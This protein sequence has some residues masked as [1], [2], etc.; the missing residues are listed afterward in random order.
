[1]SER[2]NTGEYRQTVSIWMATATL[3]S[4][5]PLTEDLDVDV[6]VVGAGIVG[7]SVAYLLA[8][9]GK[10]VVVIDDGPIGGGNTARTTAHLACE[11]DDR[12]SEVI[13]VRGLE[14]AR[15]A[16]ES[17]AAAISQIEAIVAEEAIDCDFERLDGFLFLAPQSERKILDDELKAAHEVGFTDVEMLGGPP[18]RGL[19]SDPCLVFPRQAQFHPLKYLAGLCRAIERDGGRIYCGTHVESVVGG[20]RAT[21]T[22]REGRTVRAGAAVVATNSPIND[23]VTTH[24]KQGPYMTYVVGLRAEPGAIPRG[25]YWD[26]QDPYHYVRLQTVRP[27]MGEAYDVLIVGG[28]DHKTGQADDGARRL[29]ALAAWA[30]ERFPGLG[31]VMYRWSGMVFESIDGAAFIGKNPGED[32]VYIATGDSGMGMTHGTIA[33]ILIRDLI[34]GVDNPWTALYAVGRK[35]IKA[36]REFLRENLNVAAQYADLLT[37]GEVKSVDEVKP[38]T[39]ALLRK[40]LTKVAVYR[41]EAGQVHACSALC[42]HMH[43]PVSWNPLESTWDCTCHGSRFDQHGRVINGPANSDLA[44]VDPKTLA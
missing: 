7:M 43:G 41:D 36:A 20:E 38:G 9:A 24:T 12:Y 22:T 6:C 35:P 27:P 30:R 4:Y 40:G 18:L 32:N 17:H 3:P 8:R 28:E 29:A 10:R 25:L 5:P 1:M 19:G 26:T 16:Y 44:P 11:V 14:N 23:R 37:P 21:V 33:G 13:R 42:P 34:L 39:G 15:L 31:D 2:A